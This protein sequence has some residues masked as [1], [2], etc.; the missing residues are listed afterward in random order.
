MANRKYNRVFVLMTGK[1]AGQSLNGSCDMEVINGN[2]RLYAY[3]GKLNKL[4]YTPRKLYLISVG[5]MGSMAVSAGNLVPKGR[6]ASI[7]TEFNPDNLFGSGMTFEEINAVAIWGEN[8]GP[9]NAILEGFVSK[10]LNWRSNL[11]VFGETKP[12]KLLHTE[13]AKVISVEPKISNNISVIE[14]TEELCKNV[15]SEPAPIED[16][17]ELS[18]AELISEDSEVMNE[19]S[20]AMSEDKV[21]EI[22][23]T[24]V[25]EVVV[26][27]E[28]KEHVKKD[29]SE[30]AEK[31]SENINEADKLTS[32]AT[33]ESISDLSPHDTFRAIAQKFRRELDM[34]DEMGIIDKTMFFDDKDIKKEESAKKAETVSK[35][36]TVS[37]VNNVLKEEAGKAVHTDS[38]IAKKA[39]ANVCEVKTSK[40]NKVEEINQ[41][42][43]VNNS[44][45]AG[46]PIDKAITSKVDA[47]KQAEA[48]DKGKAAFVEMT[49]T[50]RLFLTNDKLSTN[51][52]REWIKIDYREAYFIDEAIKD[53]RCFFVRNAARKGKHMI[54]GRDGRDIFIGVPGEEHERNY[55]QKNGFY[56]FLSVNSSLAAGYWVKAI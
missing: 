47:G 1:N 8:D 29:V 14:K 26:P 6:N 2:G 21:Q 38:N 11:E 12:A 16:I 53:I 13:K 4:T 9:N 50:D 34:L 30:I 35:E 40:I 55:A 25:P 27:E 5:V 43:E 51:D 52:G 45:E 37:K 48:S 23:N 56:D 7:E 41:L 33:A 19:D 31:L 18:V 28:V 3:V 42:R 24:E 17:E 10:R 54:I 20:Q 44:V 36:K 15:V 49:P 39:N 22:I 32:I 46:L